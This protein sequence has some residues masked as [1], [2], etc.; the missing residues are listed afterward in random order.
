MASTT[1]VYA[2]ILDNPQSENVLELAGIRITFFAVSQNIG[3]AK[4]ALASS[5]S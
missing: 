1:R 2:G 4:V 3:N 5:D